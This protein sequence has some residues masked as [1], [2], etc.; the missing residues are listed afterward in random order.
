MT[1]TKSGDATKTYRPSSQSHDGN[2]QDDRSVSA[3]ERD[4]NVVVEDVDET[5]RFHPLG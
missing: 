1:L 5:E 4:E 3:F 2:T